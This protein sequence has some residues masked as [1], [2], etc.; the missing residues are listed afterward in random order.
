MSSRIAHAALSASSCA[1]AGVCSSAASV[2]NGERRDGEHHQ[3]RDH[4]RRLGV[5]VHPAVLDAAD[6]DRHAEH[7]QRVREDRSDER[8]LNDLDEPGAQAERAD[9]QLGQIAERRLENA[10]RAGVEM[11]A[12]VLGAARHVHREQRQRDGGRRRTAG[13]GCRR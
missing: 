10:G 12:D 5:E 11:R 6:E 4:A 1:A 7:E 3:R 9:E 13:S 8:G 2:G